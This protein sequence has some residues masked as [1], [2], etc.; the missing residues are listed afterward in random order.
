MIAKF[1]LMLETASELH[2]IKD[3]KRA[4]YAGEHARD[5]QM[6]TSRN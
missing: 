5:W 2:H 3:N 6:L 4:A 1:Q